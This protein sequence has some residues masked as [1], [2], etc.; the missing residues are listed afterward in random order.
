MK[1]YS[2]LLKGMNL[3]S[4]PGM[5]VR[6][7]KSTVRE[8]VFNILGQDLIGW[9]FLDLCSGS[10][11]MAIEALSRGAHHV[12]M[13][14]KD[15]RVVKNLRDNADQ[16][17]E[18]LESEAIRVEVRLD[19]YQAFVRRA[20]QTY[21]IVYFDP[22]FEQYHEPG[23]RKVDFSRVLDPDGLLILEHSRHAPREMPE[24]LG[25]LV[26][27]QTRRYGQ[28]ILSFFAHESDEE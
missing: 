9:S 2:G 10:G 24:H 25:G 23:W 17:R 19:D 26:R 13:L 20:K 27:T 21:D 5:D 4:P 28:S 11:V 15:R 18:R 22:P 6:P 14:D 3:K 1:I 7:T 16:A 12:T 8:A